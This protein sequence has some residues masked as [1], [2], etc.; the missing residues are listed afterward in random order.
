MKI[1]LDQID[2]VVCN[3]LLVIEIALGI[4]VVALFLYV[5]FF[6]VFVMIS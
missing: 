5:A 4:G 2:R 3:L 6:D 1:T